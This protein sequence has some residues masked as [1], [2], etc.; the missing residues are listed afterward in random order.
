MPPWAAH[1]NQCLPHLLIKFKGQPNSMARI[2]ATKEGA[3]SQVHE[4]IGASFEI[5]RE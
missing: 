3:P 4:G 1:L 5:S 2:S